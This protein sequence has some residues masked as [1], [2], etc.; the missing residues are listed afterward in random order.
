VKIITVDPDKCTGCRLC[1]LACSLKNTG[2]FNPARARIQVIGFDEVFCLPVTC[3][4]CEQPYCAELCPISAITKEEALGIIRVS[5][6]KCVGCKICTLACPFG[7]IVFSTE[8][9]VAVKCE[10][11]D[12]EP[13]C[14]LFCPTGALEFREADTAMIRKKVALSEKL[15]GIY[16]GIK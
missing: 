5:K 4:H 12:G 15:K 10:L 2:E 16:E 8:E 9:K 11:C 1:E 14:V 3:F 13:E 6:E 7:N